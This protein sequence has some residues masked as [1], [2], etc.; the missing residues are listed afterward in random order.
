MLIS[1]RGKYGVQA[2]FHLATQE[3]ETP[4]SIKAIAARQQLPESYLEQLMAPLRRAG[5]VRSIR[6][7][8]GGYLLGRPA[9][10]ITVGDILRVL[11]GPMEA[12]ECSC[13][14]SCG[15]PECL[16]ATVWTGLTQ[17]V[18]EYLDGVSVQDLCEAAH[19]ASQPMYYI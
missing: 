13:E 11:E 15:R 6:G 16:E 3:D 7:A 12:T 14:T 18:N 9:D 17:V 19:V 10:E 1:T 4:V 2:I 8:Q 5:L